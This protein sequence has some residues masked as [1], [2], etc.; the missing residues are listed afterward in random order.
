MNGK[1]RSCCVDKIIINSIT[2]PVAVG[3]NYVLN[4]NYCFNNILNNE[5][6]IILLPDFMAGQTILGNVVLKGT[7]TPT[8]ITLETNCTPNTLIS[9]QLVNIGSLCG[10]YGSNGSRMKVTKAVS[11]CGS[12]TQLRKSASFPT[13]KN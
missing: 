10:I 9:D 8:L 11:I 6:F 12:E 5:R 13:S 2:P 7:G 1:G 3:D 4:T